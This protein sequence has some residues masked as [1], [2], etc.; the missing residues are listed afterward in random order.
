VIPAAVALGGNLGGP[1]RAF[2]RARRELADTPGVVVQAASSL[3]R[4]APWGKTDQPDFLNGVLL[5]DT[6]LEPE[7]L[8]NRL[9]ELEEREGREPGPRWGPR[10]L[11]LDL[12]W[13]GEAVRETEDL[14]LPHPRI[15]E[16]SFVLE[17]AAEVAP[18]WRH[19]VDGRTVREMRQALVGTP[20]WTACT[21]IPGS[22]AGVPLEEA[23]C[24]R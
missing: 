16:R 5:L 6:A 23:A 21:L 22:R 24:R 3:W 13:H 12:L 19:P 17:P 20:G 15:A 8:L 9:L 2:A 7:R 4:T 10:P 14:V 1:D 18:D 11:D